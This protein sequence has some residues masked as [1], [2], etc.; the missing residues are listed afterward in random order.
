MARA[1]SSRTSAAG[2]RTIRWLDRES[3]LRAGGNNIRADVDRFEMHMAA[4]RVKNEGIPEGRGRRK[5]WHGPSVEIEHQQ[6]ADAFAVPA[7]CMLYELIPTM[8]HHRLTPLMEKFAEA[9]STTGLFP[10]SRVA[11]K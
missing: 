5:P 9:V 11:S 3:L 6:D 10:T 7:G 8:P 4:V 2:S 1:Q